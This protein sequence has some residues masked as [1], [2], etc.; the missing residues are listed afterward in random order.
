LIERTL[1]VSEDATLNM[2]GGEVRFSMIVNPG[3]R[4]SYVTIA[5]GRV[6]SI[7][8]LS[9]NGGVVDITGGIVSEINAEHLAVVVVTGGEIERGAEMLG[10]STLEVYGGTWGNHIF[11]FDTSYVTIWGSQFNY[12]DGP[13]VPSSGT[14]TGVLEDGTPINLDF[15]RASTATIFLPEPSALAALGSGIAMLAL[16]Y[17]RRIAP[18][19][20]PNAHINAHTNQAA[21]D[22]W[23]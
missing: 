19:C 4:D 8:V 7:G 16:L 14:L 21:W 1:F 5:G 6:G 20:A 13:L 12:P 23:V 18:G 22:N 17:R 9:T 11:A 10:N 3:A 15:G 2:S